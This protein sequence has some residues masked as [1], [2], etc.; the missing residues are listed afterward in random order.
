MGKTLT[1]FT[2]GGVLGAAMFGGF[3]LAN[4]D[5][6]AQQPMNRPAI[7]VEPRAAAAPLQGTLTLSAQSAPTTA[8]VASVASTV[9]A[10]SPASAPSANTPAKPVAKKQTTTTAKTVV[11]PPVKKV[12]ADSPNSPDS[13]ASYDSPASAPSA[14][15]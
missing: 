9:S 2:I 12:V 11:K 4:A 6:Q 8:S 14:D 15:S 3:A 7:T 10:N 5:Q 13:P 1:T